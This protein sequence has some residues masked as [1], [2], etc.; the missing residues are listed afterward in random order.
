MSDIDTIRLIIADTGEG[1]DQLLSDAQL[2]SFLDLS[3][4]SVRL[5]AASALEAIAVS[6]V[7]VSKKI[8]TQ[9]LSTDG[10]AVVSA[11]LELAKTQRTLEDEDWEGFDIV[12]TVDPV[13]RPE[14]TRPVVW[15]L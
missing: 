5:A 14:H 13:R 1:E 15:G 6:E 3:G 9:D 2:Q 12:P 7:L 11:L 10:P 4:G 8:R